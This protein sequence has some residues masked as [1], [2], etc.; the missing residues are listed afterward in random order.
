MSNRQ[1]NADEPRADGEM[2]ARLE[3][4]IGETRA[5]WG[6]LAGCVVRRDGE[7]G[8]D[9]IQPEFRGRGGGLCGQL[10]SWPRDAGYYSDIIRIISNK[11]LGYPISDG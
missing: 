11:I 9:K 10:R 5:R 3:A 1:K 2:A 4:E 7:T 6:I 8:K